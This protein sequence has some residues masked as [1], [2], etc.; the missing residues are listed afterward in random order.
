M[1]DKKITSKDIL[2]S[3]YYVIILFLISFIA[4]IG[5]ET[6]ANSKQEHK[7]SKQERKEFRLLIHSGEL[8]DVEQDGRLKVLEIDTEVIKKNQMGGN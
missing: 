1:A 2:H 6:Y 4:W 8:K 3:I 7:E 5:K